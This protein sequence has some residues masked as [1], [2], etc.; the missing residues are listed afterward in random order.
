MPRK[1]RLAKQGNG[2]WR[3]RLFYASGV[4][5]IAAI[6]YVAI[7]PIL[8]SMI[9]GGGGALA[10]IGAYGA[11]PPVEKYAGVTTMKELR[12]RAYEYREEMKHGKKKKQAS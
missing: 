6:P 8:G 9:V 4:T 1:S 7:N 11:K 2:K 10:A 5:S 12:K 3:R